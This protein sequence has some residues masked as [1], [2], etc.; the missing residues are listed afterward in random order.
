MEQLTNIVEKVNNEDL[1][2]NAKLLEWLEKFQHNVNEKILGDIALTQVALTTKVED[3]KKVLE[4]IFSLY[5]KLCNPSLF[6]Q[7]S[8]SHILSLESQITTSGLK[9][10]LTLA[11]S[12]KHVRTLLQT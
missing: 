3:V 11:Q 2:T 10:P 1:E 7:E 4:N 12:K 8:K 9:L 6:T 5:I